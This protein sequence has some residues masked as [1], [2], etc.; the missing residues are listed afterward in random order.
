MSRI[1]S[2]HWFAPT[3]MLSASVAGVLFAIG[4]HLFYQSIDGKSASRGGYALFGASISA[5]ETAIATGTAFAFIVKSC[6]VL[7]VA[8]AAVQVF[9]GSRFIHDATIPPTLQ[10]LD[11]AYSANSDITALLN[12]R[13]WKK[14][15][16]LMVLALIGWS[17]LCK[18]CNG[19]ILTIS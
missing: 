10:R 4:H 2:I 18:G 12:W 15:P 13:T 7:A 3:L 14:F 6:L 11:S 5:Q 9:W 1:S 16:L 17:V 8:V 19:C